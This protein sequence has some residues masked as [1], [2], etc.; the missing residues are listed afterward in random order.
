MGAQ[1]PSDAYKT[2]KSIDQHLGL[3]H[4]QMKSVKTLAD[5]LLILM[6]FGLV[7]AIANVLLG[8]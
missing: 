1:E 4:E 3:I 8:G 2:L 6:F 7:A 5:I